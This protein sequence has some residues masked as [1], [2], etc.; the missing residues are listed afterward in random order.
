MPTS[1]V[2]GGEGSGGA[3]IGAA[4]QL[5]YFSGAN[6]VSGA[7]GITVTNVAGASTIGFGAAPSTVGAINIDGATFNP[8][9]V[10]STNAVIR[11]GTNGFQIQNSAGTQNN[12]SITDSGTTAVFNNGTRALQLALTAATGEVPTG[13]L[14]TGQGTTNNLFISGSAAGTAAIKVGIAYYDQTQYRSALEIANSAAFPGTLLLMKSG[15]AVVIGTDTGGAQLLR[16]G[17]AIQLSSAI[18]L[19]TKT[20]FTNNAGGS[21]GTLTNAPAV[22]NP[23]KWIPIDDNGTTRNIPA[24]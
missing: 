2:V 5:A 10:F 19:S 6:I 23:T 14:I 7:S 15:G 1:I 13:G 4:G 20:T 9:I 3:T 17:G 16:V 21:A 11:G 18:M 8:G 24:W 12:L 22:G